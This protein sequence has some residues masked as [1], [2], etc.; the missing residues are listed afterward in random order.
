L[1]CTRTL[2]DLTLRCS[3]G[4][5]GVNSAPPGVA[6][7]VTTTKM[8]KKKQ[9]PS[10]RKPDLIDCKVTELVIQVSE[11]DNS[12]QPRAIKFREE[13]LVDFLQKNVEDMYPR[14]GQETYRVPSVHFNKEGSK[15]S[16]ELMN[17]TGN[18]DIREYQQPQ[19]TDKRSDRAHSFICD[20]IHQ[21]SLNSSTTGLPPFF[22]LSSYEYDHFLSRLKSSFKDKPNAVETTKINWPSGSGVERGEADLILF[23]PKHVIFVEVKAVGDNFDQYNDRDKAILS[24]VE[25]AV[26]QLVRDEKVFQHVFQDLDLQHFQLT[27]IVALP[28]LMRNTLEMALEKDKHLNEKCSGYKFLC[29]EDF[30]SHRYNYAEDLDSFTNWWQKNVFYIVQSSTDVTVTHLD[31]TKVLDDLKVIV[32]RYVGFLSVVS[33]SSSSSLGSQRREIRRKGQTT[34]CVG[35]GFSDIVLTRTQKG[36]IDQNVK[37][38][39]LSGPPGSGKT[40]VLTIRAR[41]WIMD[42]GNYVVVVNMYRGESGRA[43]G[44]KILKSI[45]EH[46]K[47]EKHKE[48][49]QHCLEIELDVDNFNR[50]QFVDKVRS[51]WKDIGPCGE[52]I[53]FLVDETYVERYWTNVFTVL[54]E[55]FKESSMW[56]AGLYG[57]QPK[58]FYSMKLQEVI[59]CPPKIQHVLSLIDWNEERKACY[60]LDSTTA[61]LPT[62]GPPVLTIRHSE[63]E[64]FAHIH[65]SQCHLCGQQL[66]YLLQDQLNV[67]K[68]NQKHES[69]DLQECTLRC[70]DV[71]FLVNMPRTEYSQDE[72]GFLDTTKSKYKSYMRAL[73]KCAMLNVLESAGYPY[74]VHTNLKCLELVQ[75]PPEQVINVT[76][77]YTYQGLENTVVIFL[78]GDEGVTNPSNLTS[79]LT[80]PTKNIPC[81]GLQDSSSDCSSSDDTDH[82]SNDA[83]T[84]ASLV[85]STSM[86]SSSSQCTEKDISNTTFVDK[87][88]SLSVEKF[89][90][91]E[92]DVEYYSRWDKNN[93]FIT[94]SRCT[95][96]LIL[97]TQ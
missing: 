69:P 45:V 24:T 57:E 34:L 50:A 83:S 54:R 31:D 2:V 28:N 70:C 49:L 11:V 22:I 93:L 76:W 81:P 17:Q 18:K 32:G 75:D 73:K 91:Q 42:T 1:K 46:S 95:S 4:T 8:G 44:K 56:C 20:V 86:S 65:P 94:A 87:V 33:V 40:V 51:R 26:G 64:G 97:I 58:N 84:S 53:M 38:G 85:T 23:A 92:K 66:L 82:E 35:K 71:L 72:V 3:K 77:I 13:L 89:Y 96:Q 55:D 41:R 63:H 9:R 27:R 7:K 68:P 80:D 15:W 43:I 30:P 16:K 59:R 29:K 37:L 79:D 74:K 61:S 48:L 90:F 25:K 52:K 14:L 10:D 78:P 36:Y 88:S 39:Y 47:E 19:E 21:L 67:E 5:D 12:S 60:I 6:E 62:D